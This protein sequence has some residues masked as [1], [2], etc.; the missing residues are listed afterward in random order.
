MKVLVVGATGGVGSECVRQALE[1]GHEVTGFARNLAALEG[2]PS[3]TRVV[4]G[5]VLDRTSVDEAVSGQDAVLSAFG[6]RGKRGKQILAAGTRNLLDAMTEHGVRRILVVSAFG[7]GES[8]GQGG[9]VF[10]TIILKL[11]PLGAQFAEKELMEAEVRKSDRDW[12]IVQPTRITNGP[13]T[14]S[15]KVIHAGGGPG[16][17]ISRGDVA[18]FMLHELEQ[19]EYTHQ[20]PGITA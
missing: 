17:K 13:A 8:R 15:W 19:G 16:A 6:G 1:A 14:G 2:L 18:A 10:N 20:A 5:D 12:V 9:F 3:G 4:R 7:T 11:T